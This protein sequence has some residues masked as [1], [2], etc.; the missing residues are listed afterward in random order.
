[1]DA[2]VMEELFLITFKT[3]ETESVHP[4]EFEPT[5]RMVSLPSAIA[6]INPVFDIVAMEG[7]KV[8]QT[9]PDVTFCNSSDCP[10]QIFLFP[11][12][13]LITANAPTEIVLTTE[14]EH[15]LIEVAINFTLYVPAE[16]NVLVVLVDEDVVL[17]PKS[18]K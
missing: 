7:F 15:P 6:V 4:Y 5:Y 12:I 8:F 16:L 11:V 10:T 14:S 13:G 9:P 1:M 2:L 17:S 18:Q 3:K